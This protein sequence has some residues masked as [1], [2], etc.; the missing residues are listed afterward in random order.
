MTAP[1][2]SERADLPG[3]GNRF[4]MRGGETEG[5]FALIEHTIPPR[6]LAAPMHVHRNEDEFS[7]VLAGRMGAQIGDEVVEAGPG[8]LVRKPRGIPH[9]FWNPG[10][11][12]TRLLEIISPAGFEQ[13]FADLAPVLAAE[14]EPDFA[15]LAAIRAR[16]SLEMDFESIG[17]LTAE[18]RL[19]S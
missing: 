7:F 9:A 13:Y 10:D 16:Y 5:R 17:R 1:D 19:G 4:L 8:E 2:E 15:A 14:G 18:H 11:E 3:L 12:E 6:T